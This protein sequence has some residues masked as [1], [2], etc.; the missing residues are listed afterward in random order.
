MSV[1]RQEC[2]TGVEEA[3]WCRE[4]EAEVR[5][6]DPMVQVERSMVGAAQ[7][8]L[9]S[10]VPGCNAFRSMRRATLEHAHSFFMLW[11]VRGACYLK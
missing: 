6:G 5:W 7:A 2:F 1:N 10:Q 9:T 3:C 11:A 8:V 4:P